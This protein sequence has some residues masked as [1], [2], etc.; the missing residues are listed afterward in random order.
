M[1]SIRHFLLAWICLLLFNGACSAASE[2]QKAIPRLAGSFVLDGNLAEKF[3]TR[4]LRIE[5]FYEISP[6]DNTPAVVRTLALLGYD[7]RFLYVG[8]HC[9]DPHPEQI[10]ASYSDRDSVVSDQDFV[11][12]DLDTKNDEKSSYIFRVNPKGV[13]A[14]AIF[15]ESNGQDDFSPDF[16]FDARSQIIEDGWTTEFRIPLSSLR[17]SS[18][19][20]QSW[21]IT[22]YRNYPREFRRQMTSNP[23]PRGANCWLCYDT[24]LTGISQL[25]PSRYLLV[26]PYATAQN[27]SGET[28]SKESSSAWDGGVD[29]KWIPKNEIT[30][31]ATVNPDFAQVEADAPQISVNSR[32]AL[33]YPEKRSFFLE[34]A[35]LLTTPLEAVYTRT[36][37]SPAWGTRATGQFRNSSYTFLVTADEGGGSRI[38]PGPVSSDLVPQS[39]HSVASIGRWRAAWRKTYAG[40]MATDREYDTGFNRVFGPDI[41][42]RPNDTN[43]FIGQWLVSATQNPDEK[44][45]NDYAMTLAWQYSAPS[46]F[47]QVNYERLGHDFRADNGFVPQVGVERKATSFG[48]RFYPNNWL[49][50]IQPG[51]T[52]DS[53]VEIG[54]APVSRS[55]FP[56]LSLEGKWNSSLSV[57]YHIQ[58]QLRALAK[59]LDH[60]FV[61]YDFQIQPS[62]FFSTLHVIGKTGEQID[63]VNERVG[64]GGSLGMNATL[65]PGAHLNLELQAERQWLNIQNH[66]LFT[67]GVAEAKITYNFSPR[68]F[69]RTIGQYERIHRNPNLYAAPTATKEGTF[70]GSILYGY[71]FNWQTV[72]YAGYSRDNALMETGRYTKNSSHFFFKVAYAFEK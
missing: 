61:A 53:T 62:R 70:S 48:Y 69:L 63:I 49:R 56:A 55:T 9:F 25:P 29:L 31:D 33:F 65:R 60:T 14:D 8:I 71:R 20:V 28:P 32:F 10:R 34:S 15:T 38:E 26:V 64:K 1:E 19:P 27:Q 16:S 24:K 72:L 51:F 68:M 2:R 37:T 58:E 41:L 21:G 6:G 12:F 54:D 50:F 7:S 57:E 5:T 4:A 43:Q 59:P 52:W 30:L 11:Q 44:K 46:R 47:L 22:I 45:V 39:G 17:Y 67:A 40:V 13:L 42:W 3:W 18:S 23:I 35:D 66:R 36:I